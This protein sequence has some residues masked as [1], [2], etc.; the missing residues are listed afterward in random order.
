ML[1]AGFCRDCQGIYE[2][3]IAVIVP[4]GWIDR[5]LYPSLEFRHA[6]THEPLL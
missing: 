2:K 5:I 3:K 1:Q 4:C 6:C